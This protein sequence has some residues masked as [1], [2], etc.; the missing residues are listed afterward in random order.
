KP[1]AELAYRA[2]RGKLLHVILGAAATGG[3]STVTASAEGDECAVRVAAGGE[4]PGL[5]AIVALDEA[6][7]VA[8]DPPAAIAEPAGTKPPPTPGT[9]RAKRSGCCGAQVSPE[10]PLGAALIVGLLLRRRR[11]PRRR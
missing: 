8:A 10:T 5:P 6:C 7:S 11:W 3:K 9:G 1:G 2:P 4:L